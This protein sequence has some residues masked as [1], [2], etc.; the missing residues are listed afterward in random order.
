[1][2]VVSTAIPEVLLI[3]PDI[4][5]DARGFFF[6]SWN[7]SAFAKHG[8]AA[9]FVQDSHSRSVKG[10]VRG[11][12]YQVVKPQG[13]LVRVIK[14]EVLDVAVDIRRSSP[15]FARHVAVV[16]SKQNR[17]M[18]WIPPGFAHG[19]AVVSD[20]A[21]MLYKQTDFYAPENERIILWN[22]PELDIEWPQLTQPQLSEKDLAGRPLKA[23]EIYP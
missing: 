11:L 12:H 21:E 23:A 6:E 10:V 18:L 9:D 22:D 20:I 17:R 13:K 2:K 7:K 19:F 3:E 16:L 15:T 1:M 4:I 8:I 14:G 5:E